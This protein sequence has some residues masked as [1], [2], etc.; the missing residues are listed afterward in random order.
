MKYNMVYLSMEG[1]KLM[2]YGV[3]DIGSNTIRLC[4]YDVSEGKITLLLNNKNTAGLIGY[5]DEGNLS[6]RG[7]DKACEVLSEYKKTVS[8]IKVKELFVFATASL[9]NICNRKE[10]VDTIERETGIKIDVLSE[11]EEALLDFEG[12]A[13]ARRLNSGI[14][15]DIGGGSTETL[16]FRRGK[17]E[18]IVSF[19]FGS[20]SMYKAY[21]SGLFPR[22][23]EVEAM[24]L[25]I[26]MNLEKT[27]F[28]RG[29]TFNRMIGIGGTIRTLNKFNA[30]RMG[31]GKDSNIVTKENM[32]SMLE[33]LSGNKKGILNKVLKIAPERIHTLI[34]GIVICDTIC[35]Y[36]ECSEIEVSGFGVR[37]G[38]LYKKVV[39]DR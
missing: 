34:P 24:R 25:E 15:V 8:L 35:G 1:R 7:I 17:P 12:A 18:D 23:E 14:M 19:K 3:I 9:R 13:H 16:K 27:D 33:Y 10:A 4:I 21:V 39:M 30:K 5:A 22:E 11:Y 38:Y 32:N 28:L 20:L 31:L 29:K 2:T 6:K 36:C 37:E 26:E